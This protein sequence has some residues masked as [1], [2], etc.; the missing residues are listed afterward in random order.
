MSQNI[1]YS[2]SLVSDN[3]NI[4]SL[5]KSD[6]PVYYFWWFSFMMSWFFMCFVNFGCRLVIFLI[7]LS[8]GILWGLSWNPS[9]KNQICFTYI[10]CL[11]APLTWVHFIF[12]TWCFLKHKDITWARLQT[13]M[14]SGLLFWIFRRDYYHPLPSTQTETSKFIYFPVWIVVLL[15]VYCYI[16][17]IVL[18]MPALCWVFSIGFSFLY[19]CY[20]LLPGSCISPSSSSSFPGFNRKPQKER[21]LCQS[22]VPPGLCIL[23]AFDLWGFFLC[24]PVDTLYVCSSILDASIQ[25]Y[26][27]AILPETEIKI[28]V[29]IGEKF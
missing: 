17:G 21:Q 11:K 14:K 3:F 5:C 25:S 19:G 24:A 16:E 7:T 18:W 10:I 4:W 15:L 22:L 29:Y 23:F 28:I 20:F 13:H 9:N 12:F 8:V 1:K 6:S 26:L 2:L 27:S